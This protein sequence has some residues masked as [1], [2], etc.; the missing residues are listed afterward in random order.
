MAPP[1]KP[2]RNAEVK[3]YI[4]YLED[5]GRRPNTIHNYG[6]ILDHLFDVLREGGQHTSVYDM[7]ADDVA[8][9]YTHLALK[10]R[11]VRSHIRMLSGMVLH[12]TGRDPERQADI[13]WNDGAD[14]VRR[15]WIT[16]EQFADLYDQADATD[17]M[18]LVLGAYMGLRRAEIATIRDSDIHGDH[19]TI[20]GKGHGPNGKIAEMTIPGPVMDEIRAYRATKAGKPSDDD[21]LIQGAKRHRHL[22]RI[23]PE[24][25]TNRFSKLS[26]RTGIPVSPHSLRRLYATTLYYDCGA[27]IETIKALMRHSSSATTVACYIA[28]CRDREREAQESLNQTLNAVLNRGGQ[29]E[30]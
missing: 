5:H 10:E 11:T 18:V 8:Y 1:N 12:Y 16:K 6:L 13:L 25:I 15:V 21:Y 3:D 7:D 14:D 27:K 22:S 30:V 20:H 28:P 29:I 19:V 9:L 4:Q 2:I 17:R 24:T 26:K 23:Q